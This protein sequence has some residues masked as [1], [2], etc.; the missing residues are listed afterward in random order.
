MPRLILYCLKRP[1][2]NINRHLVF[3]FE[4]L[5]YLP[6]V[7]TARAASAILEIAGFKNVSCFINNCDFRSGNGPAV[8]RYEILVLL[9]GLA[10][11]GKTYR[12]D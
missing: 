10:D 1:D 12:E 11:N 7:L 8:F 2:V 4:I 3:A 5:W 9:A 6:Q